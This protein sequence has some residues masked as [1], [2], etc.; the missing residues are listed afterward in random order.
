MR[1]FC[2]GVNKLLSVGAAYPALPRDVSVCSVSRLAIRQQ[3]FWRKHGRHH[4]RRQAQLT[5]ALSRD[6]WKG[7]SGTTIISTSVHSFVHT[8]WHKMSAFFD[9]PHNAT[10]LTRELSKR[11]WKSVCL[12]RHIA[13][14]NRLLFKL[15]MILWC[16]DAKSRDIFYTKW[17][18]STWMKQF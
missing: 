14:A 17:I 15:S 1:L 5:S 16:N 11:N 9:Y 18:I 2:A 6:S 10:K 4:G 8:R 7:L 13:A 3:T 12:C